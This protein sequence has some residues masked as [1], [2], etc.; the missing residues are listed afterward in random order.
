MQ[1]TTTKDCYIQ[2]WTHTLPVWVWYN[3]A[4]ESKEPVTM[5]LLSRWQS[6]DDIVLVW[7]LCALRCC[8]TSSVFKS[9]TLADPSENPTT[10]RLPWIALNR[11]G[12]R[13]KI[14]IKWDF[15]CLFYRQP[16]VFRIRCAR[17]GQGMSCSHQRV[18]S[19]SKFHPLRY[20]QTTPESLGA[21]PTTIESN[22]VNDLII[23][24]GI[25]I[26][27]QSDLQFQSSRPQILW[28]FSKLEWSLPY[29][30]WLNK[31]RRN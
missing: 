11:E 16:I 4:V 27:S 8:K 13:I 28:P 12:I 18:F 5:R 24:K 30:R 1:W 26:A 23:T 15:L 31:S 10:I 14:K 21:N 17:H 9:N 29:Q 7:A 22:G 19:T 3:F 6:I 20:Q 2:N 25:G